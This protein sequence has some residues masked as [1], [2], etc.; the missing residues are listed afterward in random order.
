M[1]KQT[2]QR[3][4]GI[5]IVFS[6]LFSDGWAQTPRLKTVERPDSGTPLL[7]TD[8]LIATHWDQDYPFNLFCPRDPVNG[9]SYSYAGCPAVAMAQ[10]VNYLR[11]TQNTRFSDSDDYAHHYLGRHFDIDD[12]WETLQFPSFPQLNELLDSVDAVF[13]RD[14]KLPDSLAAA[15]IFACGTA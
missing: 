14:E 6:L 1:S 12:D 8:G 7:R 3:A 5:L 10:I 4:L 13:Q 15:L 2:S 11:T 9:N